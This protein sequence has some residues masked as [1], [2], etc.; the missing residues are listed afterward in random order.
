MGGAGTAE[1][2]RAARGFDSSPLYRHL[3]AVVADEPALVELAARTRPGQQPTFA[4]F[5]AVHQ[6]LLDG[7]TDPL[8]AYYPSVVGA[9]AR[10][11][12]AD[13]GRAFTRFCLAHADRIAAILAT[14]LVQTNHVQ[15]SLVTRL[16]L[17]LLRSATA[18]PVCVVEVGCSAGLNLRADRYAFS[19]GDR[20]F[21]VGDSTVGVGDRADDPAAGG[22]WSPRGGSRVHIRVDVSD[23]RLLPDLDR[24]PVVA[25]VV[26][27]DLDPPDLTDPE[28]R[29]WLRALVW[30]ENAHQAA[31][32]AEAMRVVADDPPRVLRGDVANIG[33]EVAASLPAGLPRLVVHTATRI[34]VPVDRRPAFDAGVAAFGADG[35]MLHLALEDDQLIAPSGRAGYGLTATDAAGSRRIAVADGHL[36]WLEP[37]PE[38]G[39]PIVLG[40]PE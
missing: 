6:L 25:D 15:R 14:R 34:H 37:L 36:A 23:G 22:R 4:L 12:D 5:G 33:A 20:T 28:D 38:L 1:V 40:A 16:G 18:A 27:V 30:P 29:A 2:F 11:V 31:L 39:T 26:G 9:R 24:L 8:A 13:T 19:V 3:L 7:V 21:S 35:P 32:L 10:P 17:A